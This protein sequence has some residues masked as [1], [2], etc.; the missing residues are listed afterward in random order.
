MLKA[1][2]GHAN[3]VAH[4]S[5]GETHAAVSTQGG[6]AFCFG[7]HL[8]AKQ[9]PCLDR[10]RRGWLLPT[11][12]HIKHFVSCVACGACH[13]LML[14]REGAVLAL[15]DGANGRL[16][17]GHTFS[18]DTPTKVRGLC[19]RLIVCIAAGAEHS[20]A[21]DQAGVVRT[22]GCGGSGRL[23]HGNM[24]DCWQP[25]VVDG[26]RRH[27]VL[28][29][30]GS[31]GDEHTAVCC[32][33]GAVWCWG[34][35]EHGQIGVGNVFPHQEPVLVAAFVQESIFVASVA[36]GGGHTAAVSSEGELYTWGRADSG[37]LGHG[38]RY[39]KLFPMAVAHL[40]H[41]RVVR[42]ACGEHSTVVCS[43][44][45]SK[46]QQNRCASARTPRAPPMQVVPEHVEE[47]P[48]A[49]VVSF[50]SMM[51]REVRHTL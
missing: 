14:T 18:V 2:G 9:A 46:Q 42:V 38:D 15:G 28:A 37:Q 50:D 32:S 13:S 24:S 11:A 16:G 48:V 23:G 19:G 26:L 22:W 35:N 3:S 51:L 47:T 4:M 39:G 33:H 40:A 8:P 10:P 21:V 49:T 1:Y 25:R 36:C 44:T 30:H 7:A 20:L 31:C 34:Q 17:L 41:V 27:A 43:C 6:A 5:C 29:V 12:F 45:Q